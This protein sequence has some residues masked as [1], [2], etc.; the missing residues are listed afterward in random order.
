MNNYIQE[1]ESSLSKG[2]L[3]AINSLMGR[4]RAGD[5][6]L[7]TA[8]LSSLLTQ[9]MAQ[10]TTS[11]GPDICTINGYNLALTSILAD[12]TSV[13]AE[14]NNLWDALFQIETNGRQSLSL[15]QA[16]I[17]DLE[18]RAALAIQATNTNV[19]YTHST[20]ETFGPQAQ[21][22]TD[23]AYYEN[24]TIYS[25]Y[26]DP[27]DG[28]LK[29]EF[30]ADVPAYS[31][32]TVAGTPVF[33]DRVY[34]ISV[35]SGHLPS[36]AFDGSSTNFWEEVIHAPD[37]LYGTQT[38]NLWLPPAYAGGAAVRL[39]IEFE[40]PTLL[41]EIDIN[42]YPAAP[43]QILQIAA[44]IQ[45]TN[46]LSDTFV[47]APMT[48]GFWVPAGSS[49][50][51]AELLSG[52]PDGGN[53]LHLST[54]DG[55]GSVTVTSEPMG[56]AYWLSTYGSNTFEVSALVRVLGKTP[57][58]VEA[59]SQGAVQDVSVCQTFLAEGLD[60]QRVIFTI[61]VPWSASGLVL[62][63]GIPASYDLPCDVQFSSPEVRPI[64][65]MQLDETLASR[66]TIEVGSVVSV[67]R[68][69]LTF[70]QQNYTFKH[71]TATEAQLDYVT[72]V[73]RAQRRNVIPWYVLGYDNPDPASRLLPAPQP[74]IQT[75]DALGDV[76]RAVPG[77]P[78]Q[79]LQ[80]LQGLAT[81]PAAT[82]DVTVFEYVIGAYQIN[83]RHR[84]YLP[85]GRF[86]SPPMNFGGEPRQLVL[87]ATDFT[88][89]SGLISYSITAHADDMPETGT[90]I[91]NTLD[92]GSSGSPMVQFIPCVESAAASPGPGDIVVAVQHL[93]QNFNGTDRNGRL[94]LPS[95]PYVNREQLVSLAQQ[96]SQ[97]ASGQLVA[98]DPNAQTQIYLAYDGGSGTS[99]VNIYYAGMAA[100]FGGE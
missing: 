60:W 30:L 100:P 27:R 20:I 72:A 31:R 63:F 28:M 94:L 55:S 2:Q 24:G 93:S 77:T 79:N 69:Y 98:P 64:P 26:N 15:I 14:S 41:S 40:R 82:Y 81:P 83:L 3:A 35:G 48:G 19:N 38:A 8:Q 37:V 74:A 25:A 44:S 73:R 96:L 84:E 49:G 7:T 13:F 6:P 88:P 66:T 90:P 11:I 75:E 99:W 97:G 91:A 65:N 18:T 62:R 46:L 89:A 47:T 78:W 80:Q 12:L 50:T 17:E 92:A 71:Y 61:D 56:I 85:S 21:T 22:E 32:D 57:F 1:Y 68:V 45:G 23:P 87:M 42:P 67:Q 70:A 86:V 33:L 53:I 58:T 76:M 10:P 29:L 5:F 59:M 52:A 34:G 54:Q 16:A 36:D 4:A 51:V 39:R 9:D 43:M 95:Y